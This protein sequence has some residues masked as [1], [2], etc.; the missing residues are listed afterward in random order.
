M[1]RS[2][3]T[4]ELV[5]N[6]DIQAHLTHKMSLNIPSLA[7]NQISETLR[8]MTDR[9]FKSPLNIGLVAAISLLALYK[10][11]PALSPGTTRPKIYPSFETLVLTG[12]SRRA[13]LK[14]RVDDVYPHDI[15]GPGADHS[16]DL[17]K[18]RV[19]YWLIGPQEGKRVRGTF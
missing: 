14:Q 10:T 12:D 15:F 16:V 18:G 9:G 3:S 11:L 13:K 5:C 1:I 7:P 19:T 8:A 17:P 6:F 2:H 4:V